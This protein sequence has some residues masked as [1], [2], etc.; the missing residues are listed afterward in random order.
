VSI[1]IRRD[2]RTIYGFDGFNFLWTVM[3]L[4]LFAAYLLFVSAKKVIPEMG[5]FY[6]VVLC[7]IGFI[8][9]NLGIMFWKCPRCKRLFFRWWK[10]INL[11][12]IYECKF[13]GL[14]K[15]EGAKFEKSFMKRF[16][17]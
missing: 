15:Y 5:A 16:G 7:W 8:F 1:W 6:V 3:F 2:F 13:Y 10:R 4:I 9:I 11:N 14:K 12:S 17:F